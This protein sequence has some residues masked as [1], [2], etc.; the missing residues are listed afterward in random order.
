M[1]KETSSEQR[2]TRLVFVGSFFITTLVLA[3][4][5]FRVPLKS[6]VAACCASGVLLVTGAIIISRRC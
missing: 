6:N 1:T 4:L 5:S 3:A 2:M